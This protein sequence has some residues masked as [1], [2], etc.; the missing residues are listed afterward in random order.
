MCDSTGRNRF[1]I[2]GVG[3]MLT[4][5]LAL[6]T[7]AEAA[8]VTLK[9]NIDAEQELFD[10][11]VNP[12]GQI[13]QPPPNNATGRATLRIDTRNKTYA[14]RLAVRGIFILDF[15]DG[16]PI[17]DNIPFL[18]PAA[19]NYTPCHIHNNAVGF[20]GPI[21]AEVCG[22]PRETLDDD[23]LIP[24]DHPFRP[25]GFPGSA[26]GG[27][28]VPSRTRRGFALNFTGEP[29]PNEPI[30]VPDGSG[31]AGPYVHNLNA[32]G[33]IA[34]ALASRLY[35]NVHASYFD[36]V[37]GD[38]RVRKGQDL[39]NGIMRGQFIPTVL[40]RKFRA[41]YLVGQVARPDAN[42]DTSPVKLLIPS[43]DLLLFFG[44]RQ[45][46][47][48]FRNASMVFDA[49]LR[50]F[51]RRYWRLSD[52]EASRSV[53]NNDTSTVTIEMKG[54]NVRG[55]RIAVTAE[56]EVDHSFA[57]DTGIVS[58]V[59]LKSLFITVNEQSEYAGCDATVGRYAARQ[60]KSIV[61]QAKAGPPPLDLSCLE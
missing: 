7:S 46:R 56:L 51:V 3:M 23:G 57:E 5:G 35:T 29:I 18:D 60:L 31:P 53:D 24:A 26:P 25:Q 16:P 12:N 20:N 2:L 30:S 4:L 11:P 9:A 19:P 22:T 43:D 50:G 17:R 6:L 52:I 41:Y 55:D 32:K 10:D 44:E 38:K 15:I 8:I 59:R 49:G 21:V 33:I 40:G 14:Y 54:R 47:G 28:Q 39:P 34:Q 48:P 36:G 37:E 45:L 1:M 61:Q 13:G 42:G 27:V 58:D